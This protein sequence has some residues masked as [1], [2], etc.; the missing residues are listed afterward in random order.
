M[1][2][3]LR[4]MSKLEHDFKKMY[5]LT[6][7]KFIKKQKV[8]KAHEL[9][10]QIQDLTM[11][12]LL[13]W[14]EW[15]ETPKSF[16][17]AYKGEFNKNPFR[18][19]RIPMMQF[20]DDHDGNFMLYKT[21]LDEILLRTLYLLNVD[22]QV[23]PNKR[24]ED[25]MEVD[26]VDTIFQFSF[27]PIESKWH[28][29]V[30]YDIE[31]D[32]IRVHHC[33]ELRVGPKHGILNS[34][35]PYFNAF[36]NITSRIK[37]ATGFSMKDTITNWDEY[38]DKVYS[39]GA[40]VLPAFEG[41]E[42]VKSLPKDLRINMDSKIFKDSQV[43]IDDLTQKYSQALIPVFARKYGLQIPELKEYCLFIRKGDYMGMRTF[44]TSSFLTVDYKPK[45]LRMADL[46][47]Q[48]SIGPCLDGDYENEHE[49]LLSPITLEVI[50]KNRKSNLIPLAICEVR[51]KY[52][53]LD[54]DIEF[55]DIDFD[56]MFLNS[57]GE[58]SQQQ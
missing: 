18:N 34:Y 50:Y 36:Q 1:Q 11:M 9:I 8:L 3:F 26:V 56:E 27:I 55:E 14:I 19:P 29:F 6:I 10:K 39:I 37:A 33:S 5:G 15:D 32:V 41:I 25:M 42:L 49:F 2:K 30:S 57:I 23:K 38:I 31:H 22:F 44:V 12:E 28:F 48:L 58:L 24:I 46:L 47:F 43:F 40:N 7:R 21:A 4:S 20:S 16:N 54:D 17:N 35:L 51:R 52:L 53:E 45:F 13:A